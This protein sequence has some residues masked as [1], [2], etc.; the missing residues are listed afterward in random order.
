MNLLNRA[1]ILPGDR[2]GLP[3]ALLLHF[4]DVLAQA[5]FQR[6]KILGGLVE[7][8]LIQIRKLKYI[9]RKIKIVPQEQHQ[10]PHQGLIVKNGLLQHVKDDL[11]GGK[12]DLRRLRGELLYNIKGKGVE[13][14]DFCRD[15]QPSI[16]TVPKL[17]NRLVGI[18]D[19]NNLLGIDTFP[20]HQIFYLCRHGGRLAGAGARH[21]ETVVVVSDD[22]PPLFLVQLNAGVDVLENIVK[23]RFFLDKGPV[24]MIGIVGCDVIGQRMHFA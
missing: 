22:R 9:F 16:D 8:V 1:Q 2:P 17:S 19:D 24:Y 23:I 3:G 20:L 7:M 21:K 15:S 4:F 13:G 14:T 6:L 10:I 18:G 11:V 5:A 12:V